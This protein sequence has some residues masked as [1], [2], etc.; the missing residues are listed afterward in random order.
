[1]NPERAPPRPGYLPY[2][3][4]IADCR[5]EIMVLVEP[6]FISTVWVFCVCRRKPWRAAEVNE[7]WRIQT[8]HRRNPEADPVAT[9]RPARRFVPK[10]AAAP[11]SSNPWVRAHATS[12]STGISSRKSMGSSTG[13]RRKEKE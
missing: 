1:M 3:P 4:K 10:V 6:P 7:A 13:N 12:N 9:A 8:A 11:R 5:T 2:L